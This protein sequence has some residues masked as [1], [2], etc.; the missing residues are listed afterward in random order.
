MVVSFANLLVQ[1]GYR[2]SLLVVDD[3]K[4][5]FYPIDSRINVAL[6]NADFGIGNRVNYMQRKINFAKDIFR[7]KKAIRNINPDIVITTEYP[8]TAATILGGVP[9]KTKVI[10]WQHNLFTIKKSFLWDKASKYAY[11]RVDGIVAL[12]A[13]EQEYYS[14]YNNRTVVIPNFIQCAESISDVSSKTILTVARFDAVKGIDLLLQAAAIVLNKYPGWQWKLIGKGDLKKEY[15]KPISKYGWHKNLIVQ[16][17]VSNQLS[18]EYQ[19]SAIYALTSRKELFPLVLL[20]AMSYGVP[21]VAFD[22]DTGPRHIITDNVDGILV[23]KENPEKL[24]ET[25]S[26]LIEDKEK[27]SQMGKAALENV[28]RFLSEVVIKKWEDFFNS[29]LHS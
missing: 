12:N 15:H 21:C 8:L 17:P 22:C 29:L 13:V 28:Q 1:D 27:R 18:K 19:Q 3:S 9:A 26:L 5:S 4:E 11:K 14:S 2:I 6:L 7:L 10:C 16:P 24:A 23:E 20:E 25:I